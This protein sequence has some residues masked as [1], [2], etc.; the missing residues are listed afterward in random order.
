[1]VIEISGLQKIVKTATDE[2]LYYLPVYEIYDVIEAAHFTFGCGGHD[3]LRLICSC[4][5]TG[6]AYDV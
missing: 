4:L 5:Y 6:F 2:F 1:M 3:R